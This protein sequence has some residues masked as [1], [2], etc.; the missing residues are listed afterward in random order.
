MEKYQE[1]LED[2]LKAIVD[3][4][5]EVKVVQKLDEMGVLLNVRVSQKDMGKVIGR[6]GDTIS[7]IRSLVGIAGIKSHARVNVK[8][9]EPEKGE[10]LAGDIEL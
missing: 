7:A 10:G 8:L 3:Y 9:E 6:K 2:I 4:P 1:L 5:D